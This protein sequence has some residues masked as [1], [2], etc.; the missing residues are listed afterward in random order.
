MSRM[1]T[2][3]A[4]TADLPGW[5]IADTVLDLSKRPTSSGWVWLE[6]PAK[7]GERAPV[8]G[9][10]IDHRLFVASDCD[11]VGRPPSTSAVQGGYMA[12]LV[13]VDDGIALWLPSRAYHHIKRI[14]PDEPGE[15]PDVPHWLPI[16]EVLE[17]IPPEERANMID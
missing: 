8:L 2:R 9:R 13:G 10:D 1:S 5:N 17:G 14:N 4:T 6:N 16:R 11:F 12:L 15:Q 3:H 7:P